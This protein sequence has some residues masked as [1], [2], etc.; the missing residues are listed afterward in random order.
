MTPTGWTFLIVVWSVVGCIT[1]WCLYRVLTSKRHWTHPDEDIRE[2]H[3]GEFG[4][5]VPRDRDE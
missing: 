5:P 1:G 4:E 2:L 3:H